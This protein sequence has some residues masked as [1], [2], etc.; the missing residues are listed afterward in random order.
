MTHLPDQHSAEPFEGILD[1]IEDEYTRQVLGECIER[2][3]NTQQ[4]V[5]ALYYFENKSL[6]DIGSELGLSGER[7]R[8]INVR[9]L[10]ELRN[11]PEITQ[12]YREMK[13]EQAFHDQKLY[14]PKWFRLQE[15]VSNILEKNGR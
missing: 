12:L 13:Q 1:G 2:L 4:R 3:T 5:I 8:Q 7:I 9:A 14:T 6:A 15:Q 10:G 11:M